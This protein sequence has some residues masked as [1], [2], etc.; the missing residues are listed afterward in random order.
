VLSPTDK[1]NFRFEITRF[2]LVAEKYEARWSYTQQRPFTGL[3]APPSGWHHDDCSS[4]CSLAFY[5]AGHMSGHGIAD[6]LDEHYSGWGNTGTALAYLD[7]HKAPLDKYRIGDMAI[8]GTAS[9]TKHMVV[10]RKAGDRDSS[11]WSSFGEESGP[12]PHSLH[13]RSDFVG[14]YRHPALL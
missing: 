10:C 4:Y 7:A 6:P 1:K 2:C 9:N 11:I 8:Y 5:W 12:E 3:G 13:Y 14:A